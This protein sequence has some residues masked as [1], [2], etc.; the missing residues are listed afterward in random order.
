MN[1]NQLSIHQQ[2]D[3]VERLD[4]AL[5]YSPDHRYPTDTATEVAESWLPIYYQD[6][7][8]QWELAGCPEPN[9]AEP[10]NN[11]YGQCTIHNLMVLGLWEIAQQFASGAIWSDDGEPNT[12]AEALENLRASF[13]HLAPVTETRAL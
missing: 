12:H 6:I 10:D 11:A 4:E 9:E 8:E 1:E 13:P 7:R 5:Q 3:L 2:E